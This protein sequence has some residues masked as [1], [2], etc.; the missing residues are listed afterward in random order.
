[1]YKVLLSG[2]CSKCLAILMMSDNDEDHDDFPT[3]S[4]EKH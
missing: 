2:Y 4:A 3:F 1:M